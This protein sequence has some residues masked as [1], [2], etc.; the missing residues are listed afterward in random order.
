MAETN[1]VNR[2]LG[3][4][5]WNRQRA[6]ETGRVFLWNG[7]CRIAN[8][9][10]RVPGYKP[11]TAGDRPLKS[12]IRS[13][14]FKYGFLILT[15]FFLKLHGYSQDQ[16]LQEFKR[17]CLGRVE[18]DSI[19][20]L[21]SQIKLW[22]ALG[23][24][25]TTRTDYYYLSET[26]AALGIVDSCAKYLKIAA[27][28]G[29]RFLIV[30]GD[31]SF[32][33]NDPWKLLRTRYKNWQDLKGHIDRN[34]AAYPSKKNCSSEKLDLYKSLLLGSGDKDQF[35]RS[36]RKKTMDSLGTI[37]E[38]SLWKT[39]ITNDQKNQKI[40]RSILEDIG[41]PSIECFSS[42]E[43]N[44]AWLIAQ[45]ADNDVQFQIYCIQKMFEKWKSSEIQPIHVVYLYDRIEV[46]SGR[47]QLFG[48]QFILRK[49]EAKIE[50]KPLEYDYKIT[51]KCRKVF[52]LPSL[53][54][55]LDQ[56]LNLMQKKN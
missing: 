21:K 40:L 47:K 1:Q 51:N 41:W 31:T 42:E 24:Q 38:D 32:L 19:A 7:C 48:T 29:L 4:R 12:T 36:N 11:G 50:P 52:G 35:F 46:N 6:V 2:Q 10:V 3:R 34:A 22:K 20:D 44:N 27:N 53:E 15:F 16:S 5:E 25:F 26:Y 17:Y 14:A 45:H 23:K 43:R 9:T 56:S 28:L 39:Q 33:D 30:N 54:S 18:I 13:H 8:P 55:Y 49:K 37:S